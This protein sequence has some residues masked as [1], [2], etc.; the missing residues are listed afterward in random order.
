MLKVMIAEDD[1]ILADMLEDVLV[2]GGYE[3][4]GIANTVEGAV[5]LGKRH[6]PDLAVLDIRLAKGGLGTDIP[7]RLNRPANMGVL[8]ATGHGPMNLTKIDGDA[9]IT[10]PYRTE[11]IVRSLKIV[12]DIV[13]TGDAAPPYPKGLTVTNRA[14]RR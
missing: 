3:V 4:C 1:L 5:E 8:F 9:V 7:A 12:E 13:R 6:K 10:K 14:T 11:D 2:S